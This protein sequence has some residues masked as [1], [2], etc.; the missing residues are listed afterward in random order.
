MALP[1]LLFALFA[2]IFSTGK[3]AMEVSGPYFVTFSRMTLAGVLILAYHYLFTKERF[4]I[5]ASHLPGLFILSVFNIFLAN[6]L[7]FWGLQYLSAAKTCLLFSLSPFITALVAYFFLGET[8]CKKKWLGLFIGISGFIPILMAEGE[9]EFEL[10]HVAFFSWAELS[11]L[12][13]ASSAVTG[14][15]TLKKLVEVQKVP[16][17]LANGVSMVGGGLI[18]LLASFYFEEWSPTPVTDTWTFLKW[19]G[20][21]MLVSNLICYNLYGYLLKRFS[22]TFLSLCGFSSPLFASFYGWVL[23]GE[24]VTLPFFLSCF[25]IFTGVFFFYQQEINSLKNKL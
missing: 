6:V 20:I 25:I 22:A 24:T 18:S 7:E 21:L 23:L 17:L 2:S 15:V 13:A 19:G 12:A 10:G 14:W 1:F 9:A 8:M 4:P 5:K 16:I 11:L 3:L